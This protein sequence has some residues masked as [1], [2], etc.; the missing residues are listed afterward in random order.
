M[1]R[2]AGDHESAAELT[3][4]ALACWPNESQR[5]PDLPD[6]PG[7]TAIAPQLAAQRQAAETW[8]TSLQLP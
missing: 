2:S 1:A 7:L 4:K 5:L 8:L 6:T 3:E